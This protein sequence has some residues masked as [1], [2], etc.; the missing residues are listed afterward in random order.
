MRGKE[1]NLAQ[2]GAVVNSS[3]R[4]PYYIF[5]RGSEGKDSQER[6]REESERCGYQASA[7][8]QVGMCV[9]CI[10]LYEGHVAP[11]HS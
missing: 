5:C 4:C 7:E 11:L 3:M 8:C 1:W 6:R 2:G 10:A 9:W